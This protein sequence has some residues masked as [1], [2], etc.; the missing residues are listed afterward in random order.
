MLIFQAREQRVVKI[1][2]KYFNSQRNSK[3]FGRIDDDNTF[4][5]LRRNCISF[6]E[7]LE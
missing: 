1:Q 7:S 5:G 6:R 2:I 4:Q 3:D